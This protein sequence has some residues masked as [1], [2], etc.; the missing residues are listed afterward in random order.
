MYSYVKTAVASVVLGLGMA[1]TAQA[2]VIDFTDHVG[3]VS[4]GVSGL[5]WRDFS[6]TANQSYNEVSQSLLVEGSLF[7]GWRYAT[8][9]EHA[10]MVYNYTGLALGAVPSDTEALDSLWQLHSDMG[11][12][13]TDHYFAGLLNMEPNVLPT[14]FFYSHENLEVS[15]IMVEE[16]SLNMQSTRGSALSSYLVRESVISAVPAPAALPMAMLGLGLI[17]MVYRKRK[18]AAK[19]IV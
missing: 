8:R 18:S 2:A 3:Y 7:E 11:A 12:V 9:D 13:W 10:D 1:G 5:D 16:F 4:D 17:G 6:G 19:V 14:I 15:S